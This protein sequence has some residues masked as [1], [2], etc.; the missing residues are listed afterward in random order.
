MKTVNTFFTSLCLYGCVVSALYGLFL[1]VDWLPLVFL[2][3]MF[4]PVWL[5]VDAILREDDRV[6]SSYKEFPLT[7]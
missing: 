5:F 4:F 2:V 7:D 6:S 1:L 3:G